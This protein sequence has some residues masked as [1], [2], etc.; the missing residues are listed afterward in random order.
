[1]N[2]VFGLLFMVFFLS[3]NS[4]CIPE[5]QLVIM[6]ID[7]VLGIYTGKT[8]YSFDESGM[9]NEIQYYCRDIENWHDYSIEEL[10]QISLNKIYKKEKIII[11]DN[12]IY[13][14]IYNYD[15]GN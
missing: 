13:Q 10:K 8:I 5:N 15:A 12:V 6:S 7:P 4:Y 14:Y 3:I 1:M 9:I 2:R 11:G